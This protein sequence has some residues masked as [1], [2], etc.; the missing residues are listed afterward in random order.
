MSYNT[1]YID[2]C[3]YEGGGKLEK[4]D[5]VV[6]SQ[7]QFEKCEDDDVDIWQNPY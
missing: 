6:L 5:V 2:D 3:Q 7:E 4:G 1:R